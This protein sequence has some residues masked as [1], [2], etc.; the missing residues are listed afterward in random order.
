MVDQN[1][2]ILM[3]QLARYEKNQKK[4]DQKIMDYFIEDY[5][6]IHNFK[7]RL[8]ITLITLCFIVF[9]A[10]KILIEGIIFPTSIWHLVEV[11]IKPYFLPWLIGII[12]YTL[13]SSAVYSRRYQAARKR[14]KAY[15]RTIKNLEKCGRSYSKDEGVTDEI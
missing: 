8:G 4:Q 5:V 9:H 3:T 13:I 15:Q 1:K 12:L 10:I 2:I 14:F 6:Y 7:T 11:Y